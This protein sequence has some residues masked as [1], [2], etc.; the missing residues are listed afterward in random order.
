MVASS[1]QAAARKLVEK[2]EF[3]NGETR[4]DNGVLIGKGHPHVI[5]REERRT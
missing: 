5:A 4:A 1:L 2:G 3:T